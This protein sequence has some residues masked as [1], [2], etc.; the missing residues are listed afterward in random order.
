M[1]AADKDIQ[2]LSDKLTLLYERQDWGIINA[3]ATRVGEFIQF[4]R[5][6]KLA[7]AQQ[8]A[9]GELVLASMNEARADGTANA[10]LLNEFRLFLQSNFHGL[11]QQIKYWASL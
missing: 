7:P 5:N 8:F 9:M 6:A 3:D 4:C 10:N 1:T 11:P 2:A